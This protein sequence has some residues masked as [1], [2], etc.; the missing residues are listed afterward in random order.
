MKNDEKVKR[1]KRRIDEYI[2]RKIIEK[3][4][5][6]DKAGQGKDDKS[7]IEEGGGGGDEKMDEDDGR[8]GSSHENRNLTRRRAEEEEAKLQKMTRK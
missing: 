7:K 3:E 2:E 6:G 8:P 1:T 5:E 4:Q